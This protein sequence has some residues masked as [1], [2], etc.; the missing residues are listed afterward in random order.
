[1]YFSSI[2][3]SFWRSLH[4]SFVMD[5]A[6]RLPSIWVLVFDDIGASNVSVLSSSDQQ[7]TV[8]FD[9]DSFYVTLSFVYVNV[10][11]SSRRKLWQDLTCI[12]PLISSD[13]Y[14]LGDF[15]ACFGAHEKMGNPP[16]RRSCMEFLSA[17]SNCELTCLDT[18]GAIYTWTNNRKG[19]NRVDI[20]LDRALCNASALQRGNSIECHA[21]AR[22]QSDHN[23]LILNCKHYSIEGH[24]PFK[25]LSMWTS[26][27][28]FLPAVD[29]FWS[30][31]YIVGHPMYI[32]SQKLKML[33]SYLR[34]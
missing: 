31:F 2:P 25:F 15:N 5:N 10:L 8:D 19:P 28:N 9:L 33:R 26:H 30:S 23:P 22:H 34:L 21:L 20:R 1:M 16:S 29:C 17:I 32:L 24:R 11:F 7:I 27:E 6:L 18:K 3:S 4:L 12:R 13:W 14:M